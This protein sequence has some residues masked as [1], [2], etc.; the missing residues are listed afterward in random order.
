MTQRDYLT[1]IEAL[2]LHDSLIRR[3][4]GTPGLRDPGALESALYR[5]QTGY[6]ADLVAEAAALLES[7][8]INH[9]FIDGN[10]RVAVAATDVFLRING[11]R[12][13]GP[14]GDIHAEMMRMFDSG[15]FDLAH[16][17]PWLRA[18]VV[19]GG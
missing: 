13:R 6:Y 2:A 16:L 12:I 15:T 7:L 14:S 1:V 19:A 11:H 18:R 9:P 17:E 5:S 3:Y 10:K 4:G 8:A